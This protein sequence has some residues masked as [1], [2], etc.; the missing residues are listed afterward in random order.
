MQARERTQGFL[1]GVAGLLGGGHDGAVDPLQ[2]EAHV[3]G[4]LAVLGLA[5]V[6]V[7]AQQPLLFRQHHTLPPAQPTNPVLG[8]RPADR[9]MPV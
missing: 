1:G 4:V 7:L 8:A 2:H 6:A 3:E 9:G 5:R